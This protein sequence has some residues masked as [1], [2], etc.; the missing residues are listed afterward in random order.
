MLYSASKSNPIKAAFANFPW[1]IFGVVLLSLFLAAFLGLVAVTGSTRLVI[2]FAGGIAGLFVLGLSFNQILILMVLLAFFV[3]GQVFYFLKIG[4]AVWIPYGLGIALF[5]K[6]MV[7]W[8]QYSPVRSTARIDVLNVLVYVLLG[9]VVISSVLNTSPLIQALAG[10]KNL[11]ALWSVLLVIAAGLVSRRA[12]VS[13]WKI[14]IF[15]LLFQ[16]PIVLY[17]YLYVA[18]N[19]TH[20]GVVMGG[21]EWDAVVGGFGGSADGGGASG[22]MAF[23]VCLMAFYALSLARRRL[24]GK[25]QLAV[26]LA[27]SAICVLL[28]EVKVV[29]LLI[30]LGLMV[31]YMPMLRQRPFAVAGMFLLGMA[32]VTATL[33]SYQSVHYGGSNRDSGNVVDVFSKATA[34][35]FDSELINYRTGEMGRT[36]ALTH[37]WTENG[38]SDVF[39]SLVGYGAGASRGRSVTGAGEAAQHYPFLID[40]SAATQLLWDVGLIGFLSYFFILFIG[41]RRAYRAAKNPEIDARFAAILE[42]SAVG[43]AMM[44]AMLFYGRDLLEVPAMTLLVMLLVGGASL[45]SRDDNG[46]ATWLR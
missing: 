34:Y 25:P 23:F 43:I 19:R 4:Q 44:F 32:F 14:L 40:R 16:L 13:I 18:P 9:V 36:A 17:Q 5:L 3:V 1:L 24:L 15:A 7:S 22:S 41:F 27:V 6:L 8:G 2:I 39:H 42:A 30:P 20:S 28:A 11:F 45:L 12:I 29:M 38:I 46:K 33:F 35:S 21:V 26:V 31:M 10:G 37:W